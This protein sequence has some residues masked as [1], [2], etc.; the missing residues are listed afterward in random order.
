[1]KQDKGYKT[2][3]ISGGAD[4]HNA[5]LGQELVDE[6]IFNV[7]PVLEGKGLN[8]SSQTSISK[9]LF[10]DDVITQT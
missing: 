10:C 2:A 3:L 4:L 6:L 7:A 1:M 5:F 8:L 9:T